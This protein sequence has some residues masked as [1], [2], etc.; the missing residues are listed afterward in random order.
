VLRLD[1][2]GRHTVGSALELWRRIERYDIRNWEDPVDTFEELARLHPR[3]SCTVSTH[4]P[5]LPR[6]VALGAP[7]VFVLNLVELGG[8][9]RTVEFVRACELHGIGF[10]FHSGETGIASAAYL[11]V[12]A[13]LE[14]I[15]DPSQTLLRWM[16]DDV[17]E[18]GPLVPHGGTV[19]VPPGP[20]L[21]VSLD[22]EALA[23]CHRR[24]REEGPFPSGRPGE[25]YGGEFRRR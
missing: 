2:N 1:S 15:R 24:F 14:P 11:H 18:G 25:R 10:W 7:D 5:D 4:R 12:S 8:I 21:G 23:R 22:R 20:G 9:R 16:A 17:I 6:A 3:L 13:A 19:G